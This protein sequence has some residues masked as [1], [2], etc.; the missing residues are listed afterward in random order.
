[1]GVIRVL[2]RIF[3]TNWP[4]KLV[5]LFTAIILWFLVNQTLTITE[6]FT[7]I[8]VRVINL[9]EDTTILDITP[10][11][12][13]KKRI[14]IA[15][16]GTKSIVSELD[17][18]YLEV[19]INAKGKEESWIAKITKHSL[20]SLSPN[21]DLKKHLLAV[22]SNDLFIRLSDIITEE[23][24]VTISQPIGQPP[25]G[26]QV[27]DVWPQFL[28]QKVRGAKEELDALKEHG[29]TLTFDLSKISREELDHLR[30]S[31]QTDE[32][33]FYIPEQWQKISIPFKDNELERLNDPS[34]KYLRIVFLKQELISLG[35]ELPITI[36]FPVPYSRTINPQTYSLKTNEIVHKKNGLKLLTIPLFVQD[37]SGLFLDVVRDNLLFTIIASPQQ[38]QKSLDW[39]V[40]FVNQ[41]RLEESFVKRSLQEH[42]ALPSMNEEY[43][44]SRFRHFVHQF[45][46]YL[47]KDDPLELSASIEANTIS[48]TRPKEK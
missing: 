21:I 39:T 35:I 14:S 4:R 7:D 42:P 34:A 33:S 6:T 26:Y 10:D 8:P 47:A 2:K 15:I 38:K 19:V 16:T 24:L 12:Y 28:K 31:T 45:T 5:A 44:R 36:F 23:I 40:L 29:L 43:L 41:S 32:V 3:I 11:G 27:L 17:P 9:A 18:E 1:M 48:L 30:S 20:V 46:L 37:V 22:H 25:K 13:L